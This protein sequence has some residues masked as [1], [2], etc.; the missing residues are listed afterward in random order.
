MAE[1]GIALAVALLA[2]GPAQAAADP[3]TWRLEQPPPPAGSTFKVPLGRPGDIKCVARNRC[4]L[5]IEG[6]SA[7]PEGLYSWDGATWHQLA[8]VCGGPA[9]TTRVAFGGPS[10]FWTIT[11]PSLPRT[12]NGRSLCH[13]VDGKV[14]GSFSTPDQSPDP[15]R[16][17][18]AAACS[19]PSDCWF[20]GVGSTDPGAVRSGAFH[21]HWNGSSLTSDYGISGRGISDLQSFGAGFVESTFAGPAAEDRSDPERPVDTPPRFLHNIVGSQFSNDPFTPAPQPSDPPNG[22]GAEL[23]ALDSSGGEAWAGGGG[24]TSGPGAPS[25]GA[26]PRGPLALH[27]GAG[28]WHELTLS[29]GPFSDQDRIV[30]VAAIPGTSSA[31]AA[32]AAAD[33]PFPATNR[34]RIALVQADG[35]ATVTTLPTSGAGRGSAAKVTCSAPN[36]CW[37][38]TYA[39]WIFHYT[40]DSPV[41]RDTDPNWQRTITFRPNE[42]AE[43]FVPDRPPPDDN[44]LVPPPIPNE[45]QQSEPEPPA[46]KVPALLRR[47]KAKLKGRRKL[48][49]SFTV[50]R[51]AR[52]GL[53]GYRKIHR[54]NKVVTQAKPKAFKPGRHSLVLRLNPHRYPTKL[55]WKITEQGDQG[56]GGSEGG[57]GSTSDGDTV[58]T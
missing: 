7:V 57:S 19:G 29:G 30:D 2:L 17:M 24:A 53:V 3:P 23:L 40:D 55:K 39:G 35:T 38:V 16:T 50:V 25:S 49:V 31:F 51:P 8:T 41:E 33:D 48:V 15:F 14:A 13:I 36:D 28:A 34:A 22:P 56:T 32:V 43:Q 42:S 45:T 4:L 26:V 58:S 11:R 37:A 46:K 52:I 5:A 20:G 6:N 12:G 9:A 44:I 1:R 21:L 18:D 27:Y 10:D 47:V 54:R